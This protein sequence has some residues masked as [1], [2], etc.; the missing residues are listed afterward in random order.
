MTIE[1]K[2]NPSAKHRLAYNVGD[3]V[4]TK[5]AKID[6]K[7]IKAMIEDKT[8]VVVNEKRNPPAEETAGK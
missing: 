6:D 5:K 3:Q 7:V 8:A 2:R 1:F 4:D